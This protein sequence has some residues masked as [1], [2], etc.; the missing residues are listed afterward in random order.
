MK[1]INSQHLIHAAIECANRMN[2][3]VNI[4]IYD[5]GANLL[6]FQKMNGAPLGS[7]DVAL[8]KARSAVLFKRPTKILGQRVKKHPL[9]SIEQTSNGLVLFVGGEPITSEDSLLGGIRISG[10]SATQ[11]K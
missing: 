9:S 6:A 4:A 1:K 5:S 7:I 8:K 3:T 2:I 11:D 10:S